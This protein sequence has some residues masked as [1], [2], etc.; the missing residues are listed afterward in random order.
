[1]RTFKTLKSQFKKPFSVIST[2]DLTRC[3]AMRREWILTYM[4][5]KNNKRK[6]VALYVDKS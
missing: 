2:V 1:M 3:S 6:G 5:S 4:T